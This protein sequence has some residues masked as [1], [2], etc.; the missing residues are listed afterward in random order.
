MQ[1][2]GDSNSGNC[3]KVKWVCD[4]LALPYQLDRDRH[5][6][7]RDA[8]AAIP[9][10]E[11]RRPGADRRVRRRP[12][13]GAVQRHHPLSRPRQRADSARRL[14][15]RQDGR[16]AVLGAVQPRALYRGVPL[17]AGLSRQELPPSSIPTRSS[18]A[19]RRSTAWSSISPAAAS[20]PAMRSR[21]PTSRCSPIPAS[22]MKAASISAAMPPIRRWIAEAES[23]SRSAAGALSG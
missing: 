21:S 9:E 1:I 20:S 13:A 10:D 23:L 3:L 5:A 15:R 7:G 4:Q 16:M 6:Q 12:H 22:R 18:A 8:H 17:P 19:M 11:R 2:Y 14:R